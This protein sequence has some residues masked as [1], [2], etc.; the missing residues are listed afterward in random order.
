MLKEIGLGLVF[1]LI[2]VGWLWYS[3]IMLNTMFPKIEDKGEDEE[4]D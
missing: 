4:E 3:H 1:F 2:S